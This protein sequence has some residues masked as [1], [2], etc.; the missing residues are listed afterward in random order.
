MKMNQLAIGITPQNLVF[1]FTKRSDKM[2]YTITKIG[3]DDVLSLFRNRL[4]YW[5][6]SRDAIDLFLQMYR[7]HLENG[8]FAHEELNIYDIVDNDVI[9][10]CVV[11]EKDDVTQEDWDAVQ[12]A[13]RN[14]QTEIDLESFGYLCTGYIEAKNKD[15][16]LV[17]F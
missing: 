16:I 1:N 13:C 12:E 9:N 10:N 15:Q 14:G 7:Q 6:K 8:L 17:R 3:I 11:L 5:D 2:K 4:E